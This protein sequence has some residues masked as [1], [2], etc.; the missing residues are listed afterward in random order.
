MARKPPPK[1]P[2]C[3]GIKTNGKPCTVRAPVGEAYC[4][5]HADQAGRTD[6]RVNKAAFLAA[7]AECANVTRGC[8]AAGIGRSTYYQ[9]LT[10]DPEFSIAVDELKASLLDSLE[11]LA[12]E[13]A[14]GQIK[15][16][17]HK[18]E[19]VGSERVHD[20]QIHLSMLK[21]LAPEKYRERHEVRHTVDSETAAMVLPVLIAAVQELTGHTVDERA[22]KIAIARHARLL[23]GAGE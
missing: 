6:T 7:F 21:A 18:G 23:A 11:E 16:V 3:R 14:R 8:Q 4:G 12:V 10:L 5:T 15:A 9:W 17:W 1:G 13:R 19:I 20:T 22:A 2:P